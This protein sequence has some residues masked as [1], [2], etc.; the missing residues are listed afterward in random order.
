MWWLKSLCVKL[1]NSQQKVKKV[2]VLHHSIYIYI[3]NFKKKNYIS[4]FMKFITYLH[5]VQK[6]NIKILKY[7]DFFFFLLNRYGVYYYCVCMVL[8]VWNRLTT[9]YGYRH[10]KF[11]NIFYNCSVYKLLLVFIWAPNLPLTDWHHFI[12]YH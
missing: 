10:N 12:I 4:I 7:G 11:H 3:Y 2:L 9:F 6:R 8:I 5:E 1:L